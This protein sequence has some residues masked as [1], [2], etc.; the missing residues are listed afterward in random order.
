MD[1]LLITAS[2]FALCAACA[3]SIARRIINRRNVQR[4]TKKNKHS[5]F[6]AGVSR[7]HT[8]AHLDSQSVKTRLP[9]LTKRTGQTAAK[10]AGPRI[11]TALALEILAAQLDSGLGLHQALTALADALPDTPP[12][13]QRKR[14]QRSD[15]A[16]PSQPQGTPGRLR[17]ICA[18]LTLG[19]D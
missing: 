9:L 16:A 5:L 2:L 15:N 18:A 6:S 3:L 10:S 14:K 1:D 8:T 7:S 19:A 12:Q 17:S 11:D 13:T 4:E